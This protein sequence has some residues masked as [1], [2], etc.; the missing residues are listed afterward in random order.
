MMWTAR[1]TEIFHRGLTF[2]AANAS[3]TSLAWM[4]LISVLLL[5][6]LWRQRRVAMLMK[7]VT[8]NFE[9]IRARID[10]VVAQDKRQAA[11]AAAAF[12]K[13]FKD[14]AGEIHDAAADSQAVAGHVDEFGGSLRDLLTEIHRTVET[15]GVNVGGSA[16][17]APVLIR[18]DEL[19][20]EVAWSH[21]YYSDLKRLESAVAKLVGPEKMR[22]LLEK[23]QAA[24]KQ[25]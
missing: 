20:D 12:A 6:A 13:S 21:N 1:V 24:A 11:E 8:A 23:E 10:D 5:W 4:A 17:L 15:I 14:L 18:L 25:P 19:A 22:Q 9:N 16:D 7:L 2:A 3:Q